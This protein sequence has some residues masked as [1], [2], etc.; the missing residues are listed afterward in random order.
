MWLLMEV[1]LRSAVVSKSLENVGNKK[2]TD[3][4]TNT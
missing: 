4:I 3:T 1:R 2:K